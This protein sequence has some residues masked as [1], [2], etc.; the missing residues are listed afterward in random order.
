[1]NA[2]ISW[3]FISINNITDKIFYYSDEW[4]YQPMKITLSITASLFLDFIDSLFI[5]SFEFGLYRN[6]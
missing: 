4:T 5:A 1:M 2:R 3:N 6:K